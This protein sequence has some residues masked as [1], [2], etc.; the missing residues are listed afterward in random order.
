[1]LDLLVSRQSIREVTTLTNSSSLKCVPTHYSLTVSIVSRHRH[2]FHLVTVNDLR[3][4]SC[5][6]IWEEKN[7]Q[8][9]SHSSKQCLQQLA[10][11]LLLLLVLLL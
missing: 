5:V 9:G 11:L 3:I 4:L 7:Y 6:Q 1:M 10:V 2:T 8:V